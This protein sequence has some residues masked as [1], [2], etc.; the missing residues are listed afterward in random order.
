MYRVPD[1]NFTLLIEPNKVNF[2]AGIYALLIR[3]HMKD[4]VA[5]PRLSSLTFTWMNSFNG[6]KVTGMVAGLDHTFTVPWG[7]QTTC[8]FCAL[9]QKDCNMC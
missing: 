8:P 5:W 3:F 7:M 4:L 2:L 1:P 9:Q 6:W